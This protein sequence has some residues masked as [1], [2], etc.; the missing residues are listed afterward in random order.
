MRSLSGII[1][2]HSHVVLPI[3]RGPPTGRHPNWSIDEALA[4][5]DQ[6]GISA[7]VL[8]VP[9]GANGTSRSE[10]RDLARRVNEALAH[11]VSD[12]PSRFGALA[13]LPGADPDG[14]LLEIEHAL[15]FLEMDGVSSPTSI[16][17]V[18]LGEPVYDPWLAELHRRKATLFIHPVVASASRAVSMGLDLSILEFMFDTT[19]MLTNMVLSGAKARFSGISIIS[20]HGGGTIPYLLER[21]AHLESAFGAGADRRTQS[22]EEI[23]AGF[24]S[25]SY[26]L[27]AATSRAQLGALLELVP[28]SRLLMGF[29][30]PFMPFSSFDPAI[31]EVVAFERFDEA[32]LAK[33]ARENAALLFPALAARISGTL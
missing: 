28:S 33:I 24:A 19:R 15:D 7:C 22:A 11:M 12:H 10:G 18:Y 31:R 3:G 2:V 14:A 4:L 23:R 1:D 8:S 30:I 5:M 6:H 16:G 20:T 32:D 27:T 25:F 29:D 21:I 13:T 17:D 9:D 26:D